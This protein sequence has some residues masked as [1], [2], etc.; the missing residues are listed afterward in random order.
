MAQYGLQHETNGVLPWPSCECFCFAT[1][2]PGDFGALA[3]QGFSRSGCSQALKMRQLKPCQ[4][5]QPGSVDHL[6][7]K[8]SL[9]DMYQNF[10]WADAG[11]GSPGDPVGG[12]GR[13]TKGGENERR[14]FGN[15]S[16]AGE[17]HGT[18]C[19]NVWCL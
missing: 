2:L 10:P 18:V 3:P 16:L 15:L 1:P 14:L 6:G 7:L 12:T 13:G 17:E 11:T 9:E 8:P 5:Q 19:H 4:S